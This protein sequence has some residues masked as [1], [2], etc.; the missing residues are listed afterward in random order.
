MMQTALQVLD[1]EYLEARCSLVELGAAF[2]RVDRASD[3]EENAGEFND[4]RLELLKQALGILT[5]E[6]HLPNR[7]ERLLLLFSD[8]D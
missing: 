5:E 4:S 6:S 8:L 7:A 3:H 2:D 1:R